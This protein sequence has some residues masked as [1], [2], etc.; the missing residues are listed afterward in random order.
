MITN[1]DRTIAISY[2]LPAGLTCFR[3]DTRSVV[4]IPIG[5]PDCACLF[6]G[7]KEA[8]ALILHLPHS[9]SWLVTARRYEDPHTVISQLTIEDSIGA[10]K[11]IV[12]I[13]YSLPTVFLIRDRLLRMFPDRGIYEWQEIH[14]DRSEYDNGYEPMV[15]AVQVPGREV[16]LLAAQRHPE[17][18]ICDLGTRMTIGRF[19]LPESMGTP[20]LKFRHKIDELWITD[21]GTV[22][23][24]TT[25]DW[26]VKNSLQLQTPEYIGD[27]AFDPDETI[28]AVARPFS[29]DVV[30]LDTKT[31]QVVRTWEV[32]EQPYEVAALDA[33]RIITRDQ[34][35]GRFS[36]TKL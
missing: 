23:R 34:V 26:S 35:T 14:Y 11:G 17:I 36:M 28:C 12:D 27:F 30:G 9:R 25:S 10:I 29:G 4:T 32:G 16:V 18:L 24:L 6:A 31:F 13:W 20:V 5:K 2:R 15:S 21:Y 7:M 8:F 19:V 22:F 1:C 33:E 3:P